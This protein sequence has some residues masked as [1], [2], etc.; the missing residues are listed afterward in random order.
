[1]H[2][3]CVS[4]RAGGCSG[5]AGTMVSGAEETAITACFVGIWTGLDG[6]LFNHGTGSL[7]IRDGGREGEPAK[8]NAFS[9]RTVGT[10]RGLVAAVFWAQAAGR[11]DGGPGVADRGGAND[12]TG[13]WQG[14]PVGGK[15][16]ISVSGMALLRGVSQRRRLLAE[17][18][19][20]IE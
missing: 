5:A 8:G 18:E 13:I 17:P 10:E 3:A 9:N 4:T 6:A 12:S 20:C 2:G 11:G 16:V 15:I 7:R 14:V 19:A 1:M